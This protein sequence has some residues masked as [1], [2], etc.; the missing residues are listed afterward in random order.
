MLGNLSLH[1]L[2]V[3]PSTFFGVIRLSNFQRICIKKTGMTNNLCPVFVIYYDSCFHPTEATL[4][5]DGQS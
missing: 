1:V 3:A 4:L 2:F 5:E